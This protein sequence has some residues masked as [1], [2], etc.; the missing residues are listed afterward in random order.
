MSVATPAEH[1][2][3]STLI[4]N[5]DSRQLNMFDLANLFVPKAQLDT[6]GIELVSFAVRPLHHEIDK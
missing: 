2:T 6:A 4:H 5:V 1:W 3:N